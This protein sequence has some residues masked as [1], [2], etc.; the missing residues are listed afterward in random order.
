MAISP[1]SSLAYSVLISLANLHT[2]ERTNE[3]TNRIFLRSLGVD[4]KP[5]YK[6]VEVNDPPVREAGV[7]VETVDEL[8]EKLKNEASVI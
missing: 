8:V 5:K 1:R 3:R 2:N 7:L 4:L 6:V